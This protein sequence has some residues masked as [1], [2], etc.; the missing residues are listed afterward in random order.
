MILSHRSTATR[1]Q[2]TVEFAL[3]VVVFFFF[4]FGMVEVGWLFNTVEILSNAAREGA[5]AAALG[6]ATTNIGAIVTNRAKPIALTG[7]LIKYSTSAPYT[8]WYTVTNNTSG[9]GATNQ[10]PSGSLIKVTVKANYKPLTPLIPTKGGIFTFAQNPA[11]AQY[12]IAR[13]EI[14]P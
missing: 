5:R 9:N 13:R 11:Q 2:A 1:S 12:A 7:V 3:C 6:K 10:A 14:T 8:N 4:V